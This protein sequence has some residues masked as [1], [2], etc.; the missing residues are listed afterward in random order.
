MSTDALQSTSASGEVGTVPCMTPLQRHIEAHGSLIATHELHALGFARSSIARAIADHEVIR[1]RQGWY[2]NPWLG[3]A[4]QQAARVGGQLACSSAAVELGLWVP[5]TQR[6]IHVC[7]EPNAAQLRTGTSYR[8]RLS[9][10]PDEP[11]VVHWSGRD[12]KGSRVVVS[13]EACIRQ[14]MSCHSAEFALVVAESALNR[15]RISLDDWTHIAASAPARL[16][17]IMATA[18]HR[19][20]SGT[21][22]LF[23]YRMSQLGI[24]VRQQV[25]VDGVGYID[26]LIG[27]RL[28]IELDSIAHHSDPTNDRRRDARLSALGYRVLRFM[29]HQVMDN[30]PEVENAVLAAIS[31]GDHLQA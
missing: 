23:V 3:I 9:S 29:Y 15:R 16:R 6:N 5:G 18:S 26:C 1:I 8:T 2:A 25:R 19:S 13:A 11:V 31:R 17:A 12:L 27:E 24:P 22:S 10:L 20:D 28:V 30:W 7:V 4:A 21:E 14:V